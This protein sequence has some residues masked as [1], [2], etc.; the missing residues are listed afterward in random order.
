M[1]TT[2]TTECEGAW[3]ERWDVPQDGSGLH[4]L[5]CTGCSEF[6]VLVHGR[7]YT[8]PEGTTTVEEAVRSALA[9][10]AEES[11]R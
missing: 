4:V 7:A 2:T 3:R 11:R 10:R 6:M 9:Q 1:V 5:Q 8:P